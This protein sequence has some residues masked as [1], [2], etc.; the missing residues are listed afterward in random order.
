[1]WIKW[2]RIDVARIA[3]PITCLI[4]FHVAKKSAMS[5][6]TTL[7]G[8]NGWFLYSTTGTLNSMIVLGTGEQISL[9]V[10]HLLASTCI[11]LCTDRT[12]MESSLLLSSLHHSVPP[13]LLS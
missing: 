11:F 12:L 3:W 10:C 4:I 9:Q 1:M 13:S 8:E 7:S 6:D 5:L 2:V